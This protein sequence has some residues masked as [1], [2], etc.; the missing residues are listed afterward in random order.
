LDFF[1][2]EDGIHR[3]SRNVGKDLP[4]YAA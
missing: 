2:T 3:L 4:L 1:I